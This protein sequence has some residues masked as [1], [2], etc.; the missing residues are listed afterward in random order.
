MPSEDIA[1]ELSDLIGA[2]YDAAIEPERWGPVLERIRVHFGFQMA[3]LGVTALPS[4]DAIVQVT[5]NM[6]ADYAAVLPNYGEGAAAVWGGMQRIAQLPLEEP[7]LTSHV[8]GPAVWADIP[9]YLEWVRPQGIVDQVGIFL[10]RDRTMV[11]HVG[12]SV[13]E[14]SSRPTERDMQ[15]LRLLAPHIRRSAT[16]SRLLERSV[17]AVDSFAAALEASRAGIV[18]VGDDLVIQF[19]NPSAEAMLRVGDPVRRLA[20]RLALRQDLFPGQLRSAVEL[21]A[22]DEGQLG[23]SGIGLPTRL[24]DGTPLAI[25]VMPLRRRPHQSGFGSRAAAAIFIAETGG[26]PT[27]PVEA[28]GLIFGLTPAEARIFELVVAGHS[29]AEMARLLAIAP[30]TFRTHLLAVFAKT[31]SRHRVDLV[32]L[33][34]EVTLPG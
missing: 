24:A 6:P 17:G 5:A 30:S 29:T 21:A 25:H 9:F 13:H 20:G 7:L 34:R 16:I 31:G 26:A 15:G 18:I 10:V 1:A 11:G 33:S 23:R 22:A 12:L 4:G 14:S 27:L 8:A 32:R 28:L 19:A 2:L 3:A